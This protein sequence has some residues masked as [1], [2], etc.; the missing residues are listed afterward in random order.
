M[1]YEY[2]GEC[3]YDTRKGECGEPAIAKVWWEDRTNDSM[4]VCKEHLDFILKCEKE[5]I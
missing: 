1:D 2:L 5:E 3:E 4:L